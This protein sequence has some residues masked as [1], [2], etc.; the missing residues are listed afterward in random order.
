MR[1]HDIVGN[2][3][4]VHREGRAARAAIE[5]A[6]D[7]IAAL[8]GA[9]GRDVIFTSGGSEANALA[10]SPLTRR[11]GDRRSEAVLLAGAGE[12]ASVLAGHRFP[13]LEKL[14][15]TADGLVSVAAALARIAVLAE[16]SPQARIAVAVQAANSETGVVQPV[17]MLAQAVKAVNGVVVCDAVQLAGKLPTDIRALDAD[18]LTLSA[19]QFGGPKG[20]GALVLRPDIEVGRLIG[21]GGQEMNRRAGT[22]TVPAIVGFGVAAELAQAALE[23][24]RTRLAALR[25]RLEARLLAFAPDALIFGR[26]A[27]R[28]PNTTL[29]AMPGLTAET[30]LMALDLAGFAVSSGSAC[31]SGKVARSHVL[32]AMGVAR[33]LAEGAV[34]ISLGR[35]S[36]DDDIDQFAAA[37]EKTVATLYERRSR[38][39]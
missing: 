39:A 5:A 24:E 3:S 38:A 26:G 21:G 35:T 23:S 33:D 30:L 6:R 12:H 4:S 19:H 16:T 37:F 11:A 32:D 2:P 28:L 29:V 8:V 10:L 15:L 18:A 14:P 9:R 20:I 7:Q 25:D 34:R 27:P 13:T 17:A 22:E 1:A 31:S 36:T